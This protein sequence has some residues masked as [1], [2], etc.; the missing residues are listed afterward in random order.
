M[1]K[2]FFLPVIL[3]VLASFQ[4]SAENATFLQNAKKSTS[5][6][7]QKTQPLIGSLKNHKTEVLCG[8][9]LLA[10]TLGLWSFR[11]ETKAVVNTFDSEDY[12]QLGGIGG[13]A[14]IGALL[15]KKENET[16]LRT[17]A[18]GLGTISVELAA[19]MVAR[20]N[21]VQKIFQSLKNKLDRIP[22]LK[23]EELTKIKDNMTSEQKRFFSF[24]LP[25]KNADLEVA[26]D[27]AQQKVIILRDNEKNETIKQ[28]MWAYDNIITDLKKAYE[29]LHTAKNAQIILQ[30][31]SIILETRI[32]QLSSSEGKTQ[33]ETDL[34]NKK[35]KINDLQQTIDASNEKLSINY[36]DTTIQPHLRTVQ[37]SNN[38]LESIFKNAVKNFLSSLQ[39]TKDKINLPE[40][41]TEEKPTADEQRLINFITAK[42]EH[43]TCLETMAALPSFLV[44]SGPPGLGKTSA[45]QYYA[46]KNKDRALFFQF[47]A[48]N[49]N[50]PNI[51]SLVKTRLE[52][53]SKE[54]PNKHIVLFLDE[55]DSI[56]KNRFTA[57]QKQQEMSAAFLSQLLS[58][59]ETNN[60]KIHIITATNCFSMLDGAV[61][62]RTFLFGP[63]FDA[64]TIEF[65]QETEKYSTFLQNS[66]NSFCKENSI[67]L[68]SHEQQDKINNAITTIS[69]LPSASWRNFEN[70]T[71]NF[72]MC[73]NQQALL[74]LLEKRANREIQSELSKQDGESQNSLKNLSE[75]F[76]DQ[77]KIIQELAEE[78]K[79]LKIKQ[80]ETQEKDNKN[81][82]GAL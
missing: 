18:F 33:L 36:I 5:Q 23:S 65:Y 45:V 25:K 15:T 75:A 29:D 46:T 79:N 70:V 4:C 35:N 32:K 53:E 19:I 21:V 28:Y 80:K 22:E 48:K 3:G 2:L 30:S 59:F 78:I 39:A 10:G 14:I 56:A 50:D 47:S 73:T 54:N 62:D 61:K 66:L 42:Q 6:I 55:I 16:F 81:P 51:F 37:S 34:Q 1:K 40:N 57:N 13:T 8:T 60:E 7:L 44:L 20:S 27:Q 49:I 72:A 64:P 17:V 38:K 9:G 43:D 26:I 12:W 41:R 77:N 82:T 11:K 76:S 31:E 24:Q 69:I 74:N 58:I 63:D 67:P 71:R 52:I 68:F